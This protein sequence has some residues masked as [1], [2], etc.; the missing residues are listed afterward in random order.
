MK[1]EVFAIYFPSWHM[2]RHYEKWY[3]KGFSEWELVKST[4]P[5]F[6]EHVQPKKP[7]RGYFDESALENMI[8]QIDLAADHGIT[9]FL[10]DWYWY[11]GEQFLERPLDE[12]FLNSPNRNRLKFSLMWA[13]HDWGVWPA[14]DDEKHQAMNGNV[15]QSSRL[16]LEIKHSEEDLRNV[17]DFCSERY[18][19]QKNYWKID[20]RPVFSFFDSDKLFKYIA[21]KDV[22]RILNEQMKKN[23]LPEIFL[24]MNVGCCNDNSYFCGW[25]R[26]PAMKQAGFNAVFAYNIVAPDNYATLPQEK[27]V[28]DY[29][30]MAKSQEYCWSKLEEGGLPHFPSV[31]VGLDVSPR[32]NRKVHFPMDYMKLGYCPICIGNAPEKIAH[33]MRKALEK[34][35]PAVIINAWNEWTEGMMLLPDEQYHDGFLKAIK[36]VCQ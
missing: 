24:L 26:I 8:W 35:S 18:F 36:E 10:F 6:K 7:L 14:L 13:N 33:I 29:E 20:G 11:S 4:H 25:D 12:A 5:L 27:P 19:R 21:P 30:G 28:F 22:V 1:S 23:S 15:N 31:T 2:D 34:Q 17:I 3:G 16:F 9:G 32:W